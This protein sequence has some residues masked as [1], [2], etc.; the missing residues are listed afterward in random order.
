MTEENK[1][2]PLE[3]LLG[4]ISFGK[5]QVVRKL[6]DDVIFPFFEAKSG[7]HAASKHM[8]RHVAEK[9]EQALSRTTWITKGHALELSDD[10]LNPEFNSPPKFIVSRVFPQSRSNGQY[11]LRIALHERGAIYNEHII[12]LEDF[13]RDFVPYEEFG[14]EDFD[15]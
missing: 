14:F 12:D 4:V 2:S 13:M 9:V 6:V 10:G 15:A 3:I 5:E 11:T 7:K 1:P 8:R